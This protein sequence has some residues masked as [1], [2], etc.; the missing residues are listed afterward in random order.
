MSL[1]ASISLKPSGPLIQLVRTCQGMPCPSECALSCSA[2][3]ARYAI[4]F[5][6]RLSSGLFLFHSNS[7]L[8]FLIQVLMLI[9]LTR[10]LIYVPPTLVWIFC[11]YLCACNF[12]MSRFCLDNHSTMLNWKR[13]FGHSNVASYI[14]ATVQEWDR[15]LS[16]LLLVNI[17]IIKSPSQMWHDLFSRILIGLITFFDDA[18]K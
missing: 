9:L 2:L 5:L 18:I 11:F 8:D 13:C 7:E 17:N 15:F 10:M 4:V 12:S 6:T 3:P 1:S 16:L 14:D